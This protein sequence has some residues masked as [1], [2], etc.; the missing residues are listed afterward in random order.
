[1]FSTYLFR[2]QQLNEENQLLQDENLDT[3]IYT[4]PSISFNLCTTHL[5]AKY[6]YI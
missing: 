3:Q 5:A 1:M 2:F 4:N 6:I